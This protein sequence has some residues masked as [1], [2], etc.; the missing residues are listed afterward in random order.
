MNGVFHGVMIPTGPIGTR[1][2]T[3]QCSAV[4]RLRPSRAA[5]AR[6][7][8][9]RKFSAERA[10]RHEAIGLAGV[11]GL[12]HRDVLGVRL[13]GVGDPV[14]QRAALVRRP[15]RPGLERRLCGGGSAVDVGGRA[16]GDFRRRRFV[17]RGAGI[18]RG[19]AVD[20]PAA[21][22]MA[23]AFGYEPGEQWLEAGAVVVEARPLG[24]RGHGSPD[25][26]YDV[27]HMSCPTADST[28]SIVRPTPEMWA[29]NCP[30]SAALRVRPADPRLPWTAI[31][32]VAVAPRHVPTSPGRQC[33]GVD[34]PAQR[35]DVE[36]G[37]EVGGIFDDQM[38]HRIKPSRR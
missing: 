13:D 5:G 29:V 15:G 34:R 3:F 6:S 9:K 18:E 17:D 26:A 19:L 28:I 10:A 37:L 7:A 2:E 35:T 27:V 23:D 25:R 20:A 8:K 24:F 31:A 11:P 21:D 16:E 12:E 4:G 38:W 30:P 14:Q 33:R 36:I 22:H 1:V 32:A